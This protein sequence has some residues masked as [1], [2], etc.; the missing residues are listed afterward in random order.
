[1]CYNNNKVRVLSCLVM[2]MHV[3][4]GFFTPLRI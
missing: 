2:Y 3:T 1:M 4:G